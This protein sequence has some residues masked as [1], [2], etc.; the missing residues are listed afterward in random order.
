MSA[1]WHL[2]RQAAGPT[3]SEWHSAALEVAQD[4]NFNSLPPE[5]PRVHSVKLERDLGSLGCRSV[6]LFSPPHSR[7]G[8]YF[9]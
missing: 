7:I 4:V 8:I 9:I 5:T 6:R 2:E 1:Q 3:C